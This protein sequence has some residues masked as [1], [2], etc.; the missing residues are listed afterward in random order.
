MIIRA[1]VGEVCRYQVQSESNPRQ[2]HLVD[3]L[4]TECSCSDW[5]CRQRS[6][7]ERTK[8]AYFCKHIKAARVQF[9]DDILERLREDHLER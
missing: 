7:R 6:Y 9:T 5:T 8:K 1:I 2:F 4:D 3:L